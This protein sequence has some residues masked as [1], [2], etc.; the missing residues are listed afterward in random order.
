MSILGHDPHDSV[1]HTHKQTQK[2]QDVS[3]CCKFG[4]VCDQAF[5]HNIRGPRTVIS[6]KNNSRIG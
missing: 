3:F 4:G 6:L 2:V 1:N 5:F